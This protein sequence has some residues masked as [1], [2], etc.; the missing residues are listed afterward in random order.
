MAMHKTCV[1]PYFFYCM[2]PDFCIWHQQKIFKNNFLKLSAILKPYNDH[3]NTTNKHLNKQT[4][5]SK[6][7]QNKQTPS[8]TQKY[9]LFVNVACHF[10]LNTPVK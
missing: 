7:K 6:Q 10:K 9:Q 8:F 5:T 2:W 1:L 4:T 3:I